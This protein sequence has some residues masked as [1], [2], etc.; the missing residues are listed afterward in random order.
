MEKFIERKKE[1]EAVRITEKNIC[2]IGAIV[3]PDCYQGDSLHVPV[4]G[5][6]LVAGIGD[7]LIIADGFDVMT[8][9]AFKEKFQSEKKPKDKPEID[10]GKERK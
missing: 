4:P 10:F 1:V 5:D 9:D 3:S 7:W 2:D 6:I 8:D